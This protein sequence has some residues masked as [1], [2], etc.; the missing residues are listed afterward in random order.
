MAITVEGTDAFRGA[1]E[2]ALTRICPGTRCVSGELGVDQVSCSDACMHPG[3]CN[4]LL[5]L[6][7]GQN[8]TVEIKESFSNSEFVKGINTDTVWWDPTDVISEECESC[9]GTGFRQS[10][11]DPILA[12]ELIHAWH[13]NIK[14]SFRTGTLLDR[15]EECTVLSENLIREE[16]GETKR[17]RYA[18]CITGETA[19][20]LTSG[21]YTCHILQG[22]PL[23]KWQCNCRKRKWPCWLVATAAGWV[24]AL[25]RWEPPRRR[26]RTLPSD[27]LQRSG[28][29]DLFHSPRFALAEESHRQE[30]ELALK[31]LVLRRQTDAVPELEQ[32]FNGTDEAV[33]LEWVYLHGAYRVFFF[34]MTQG[35]VMFVTNVEPQVVHGERSLTPQGDLV[36]STIQPSDW[37]SIWPVIHEAMANPSVPGIGGRFGVMDGGAQFLRL[38]SGGRIQ[39]TATRALHFAPGQASPVVEP[40]PDPEDMPRWEAIRK[41]LDLGLEE[42]S[43]VEGPKILRHRGPQNDHLSIHKR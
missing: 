2:T 37:S 9:D 39:K 6:T 21:G 25:I 26:I 34:A 27:W 1:V 3:G 13:K 31:Q 15:E 32:W 36:R 22:K 33:L 11:G 14:A 40:A 10:G 30:M 12:H 17:C 43:R 19:A 42:W 18:D 20:S 35:E 41:I 16:M 38:K 5:E 8:F 7:E 24:R 28:F 29:E 4:L 23:A